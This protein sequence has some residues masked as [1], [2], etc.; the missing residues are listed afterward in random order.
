MPSRTGCSPPSPSSPP[1]ARRRRCSPPRSPPSPATSPTPARSK[2][3]SPKRSPSCSFARGGSPPTRPRQR[4]PAAP[5]FRPGRRRAPVFADLPAP[6]PAAPLTDRLAH[7]R[8]SAE[9][10]RRVI[11]TAAAA[12]AV[13]GPPRRGAP[14]PA[15]HVMVGGG[16]VRHPRP[17]HLHGLDLEPV[18]ELVA[19]P[20]TRS[21]NDCPISPAVTSYW[22]MASSGNK[23]DSFTRVVNEVALDDVRGSDRAEENTGK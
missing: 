11:E 12:Q 18:M 5:A 10:A 9:S 15:E 3:P 17:F 14:V 2:G 20:D 8:A 4:P 21:G 1:S 16:V 19:L 23:T 13:R 22:A 6:P 7:Y